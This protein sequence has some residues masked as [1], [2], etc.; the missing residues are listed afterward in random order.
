MSCEVRK[1]VAVTGLGM[2]TPLGVTVESNWEAVTAGR[3][4]IGPITR[5][6]ASAYR[7]RIAGE[8]KNFNPEDFMDKKTARRQDLFGQF[9]LAAA[10]QAM[11]DSGLKVTPENSG[12]I[13]CVLGCGLGGLETLERSYAILKSKGPDRVSPFFIPMI[14]GNMAP[15]QISIEFSIKGPNLCT[16]T[17]CAAGTHA[18]GQAFHLIR[19]GAC[20]AAICGGVEAV[21]T[22]L[23]VAGFSS[24][25]A[26]STRNGEP[27]KASRPF[28]RDRDGFVIGEGSGIVILEELEYALQRGAGILAEVI[29]FGMSGDAFHMTA[30]PPG[31]EGA[32]I[33][34]REALA[35][36]GLRPEQVDYINAHGT[37]TDLND[38]YETQAIKT[39]FGEHAR[40]MPISSTKSMT[41]HLLGGAG[42]VEAIYTIL[43]MARGIIPPTINYDTP[44]PE[45]DLDYVP[46]QARPARVR[47]AMSN[48]FGFGGTNGSLV[49]RALDS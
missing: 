47:V 7:T 48:S 31:G 10:R 8:V 39:V 43:T 4:G 49:F 9:A 35:D 42:G 22:E 18:I 37:S 45:C 24:M 40:K 2:V 19:S 15:G 25:K 38:L 27:E 1:R 11:E 16:C 5:F 26:L 36:A 3:S 21:I 13:A 28:D 32:V 44:D 29:G 14:I 6:D 23:A 46:N 41:G 33:C 12:L 34:M 20:L 17:A 30:P